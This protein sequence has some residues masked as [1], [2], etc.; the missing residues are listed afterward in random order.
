MAFLCEGEKRCNCE[1]PPNCCILDGE[2][3]AA[4]IWAIGGVC[5]YVCA[6]LIICVKQIF[7]CI[8][9]CVHNVM[10]E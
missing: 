2:C 1:S 6:E 4:I 7:R 8:K 3:F 5:E 10:S 9:D